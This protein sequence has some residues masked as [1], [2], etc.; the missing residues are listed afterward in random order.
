M[1]S[2]TE[3]RD[4]L[5]SV[6][7]LALAFSRFNIEIF[8]VM[9]LIIVLVFVFHELA[10]RYVAQRYGC[11]AEY[12]IWPIGIALSLL[13]ALTGII[14]AAPGAVYISPYS[15]KK[16]HVF[17]FSIAH[18]TRKEYGKIS[19]AGPLTNIIVGLASLITSFFY[20]L[21]LFLT[22]SQISFFLAFFNLLPIFP[23]DGS[24][25]MAWN[26]KIWITAFAVPLIGLVFLFINLALF[27]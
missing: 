21:E 11:F 26:M 18:L 14:F 5:I 27:L 3:I 23:L 4:L 24:K 25:V 13:S 6:I 15:R 2:K 17:A 8:P 10:H 9:L 20:T 12:R 16:S 22:I 19:I 1:T 7:V